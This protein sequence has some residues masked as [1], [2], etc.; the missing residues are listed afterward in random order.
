MLIKEVIHQEEITIVN[1]CAPNIGAPNF[2]K[3]TLMDLKTQIHSNTVEVEDFSTS[4]S[5]L[6]RSS[7]QKINKETLKLNDTIDLMDLTDTTEYS[8]CNSTIYILLGSP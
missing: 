5:P 8:S 2:I 4:L 1:L 6:D 7:R 3:H